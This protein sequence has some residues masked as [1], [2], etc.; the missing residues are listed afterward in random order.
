MEI[1][2]AEGK[3]TIVKESHRIYIQTDE[4][5]VYLPIEYPSIYKDYPFGKQVILKLEVK[6]E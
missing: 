3:L 2:L 5:R 1:I 6:D 4:G